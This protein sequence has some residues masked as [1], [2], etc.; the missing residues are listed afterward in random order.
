MLRR[1]AQDDAAAHRVAA[2]VH[3]LEAER[4]HE[5]AHARGLRREVVIG[6]RQ[7]RGFA[8][9]HEIA[10]S[11]LDEL[12]YERRGDQ[13]HVTLTWRLRADQ[14]AEPLE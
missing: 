7:V 10:E 4:L 2:Q 6:V 13:N 8:E 11:L 9:A 1:V 5:L 3:A 14:P 12:S